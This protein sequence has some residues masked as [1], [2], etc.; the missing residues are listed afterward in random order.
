MTHVETTSL[1]QKTNKPSHMKVKYNIFHQTI[2]CFV[3]FY[4]TCRVETTSLQ[5]KTNKTFTCE[6]EI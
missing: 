3:K 4:D 6:G 2:N 1:Q 5:L